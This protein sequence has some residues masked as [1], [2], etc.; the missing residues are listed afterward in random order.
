MVG[1][2]GKAEN[3][4]VTVGEWYGN[5]W[6][7]TE[8]LRSGDQVVVDGGLTLQ[9]GAPVTARPLSTMTESTTTGGGPRTAARK[10]APAKHGN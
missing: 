3:R 1:K 6:F 9:P 4:P 2:D 7:I 10:D 8:G 5:D